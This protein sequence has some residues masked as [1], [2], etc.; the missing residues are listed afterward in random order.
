[1][2]MTPFTE[3][4]PAALEV[5]VT[6]TLDKGVIQDHPITEGYKIRGYARTVPTVGE[7]WIVARIERNGLE[8]D[9][10]FQTSVV[11]GVWHDSKSC[12]GFFETQN[13]RYYFAY[14]VLE[15]PDGS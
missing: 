3:S 7:P 5:R 13:S 12:D 4:F 2:T 6:K 14:T 9:G 15:C 1:M 8:R 10:L 11:T